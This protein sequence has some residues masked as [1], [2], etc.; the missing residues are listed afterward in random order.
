MKKKFLSAFGPG[1]ITGASDDDPSGI[2]TYSQVGAQF[3]LGMLWTMLFSFPLMGAI[4]EISAWIGRVTGHGIADNLRRHYPPWLLRSLVALLFVANTLNLAADL[5][6]MGS[7][8][9]LGIG[10]P[11]FLYTV[12]FALGSMTLEVFIPYTRYVKVLKWLTL[13]LFAYVV[14]AFMIH[15]PW[16]AALKATFVPHLSFQV[17][18]LTAFIAVLGTTISP[19]M[20]FWQASEE[21]E[22][23]QVRRHDHA[24]KDHP[25]EAPRQ[26]RRIRIDTYIGMAFSNI[27]AYFIILA[28]ATTL[29][30]HGVTDIQTAQQAAQALEPLAGHLAFLLFTFGIV[31]TG[32]LAVPV[33][34]GSAAYALGESLGWRV[35]LEKRPRQAKRFY[36][37][38]VVSTSLGLLLNILQLNPIRALFW[39]AVINGLVAVP[40]LAMMMVLA[41]QPKVMGA[42]VLPKYLRILG[43]LATAIMGAAAIGLLATSAHADDAPSEWWNLHAQAT[44][45]PQG[46]APFHADY[47][48]PNSLAATTDVQATLTSTLFLGVRL[49]KGGALYANPE[50]DGGAG[51]STGF[52]VAGFPNGEATRV[53]SGGLRL[54]LSRLFYRQT[55]DVGGPIEQQS[56]EAN[57]LAAPLAQDHWT[58]TFGKYAAT[59]IFDQN[60]YAHDPRTQFMNWALM[61]NAAWDFP[62][63]SRGYTWGAA[64]EWQQAEWSWR[65]GGFLLPTYA[66]GPDLDQNIAHAHGVVSE[67]ERRVHWLN[68]PGTWRLLGFLNEGF[69]GDYRA[70]LNTPEFGEDITRTRGAG[71][72]KYGYGLNID[73][74]FTRDLGGF[75]RAGWNDGHTETWAFTE[76]DRTLSLGLSLNGAAWRRAED[77][78]GFAGAINALSPDHRAYLAA[79]GLGFILGDGRLNYGTENILETYYALKLLKSVTFTVDAQGI[80]NPG[81]NRDRGPAAVFAGRLHWEL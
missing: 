74:E 27:V 37:I 3:G 73:Q 4:Q 44:Y 36:A 23:V 8:L 39:S 21:A 25:E 69:M 64:L 12:L 34:A 55:L 22:E 49:W 13:V 9:S 62:A 77:T 1:L 28:T 20:A 45:L 51:L 19:Y 17:G 66:N 68:H 53:G 47:S 10:G 6:A 31:G 38:I 75:L 42:F 26:F 57:Q 18:Y 54:Y 32:L 60:R 80:W 2:A 5:G 58:F 43:W 59:D 72:R 15:V 67:I 29:H 46:H 41:T 24:L 70:T 79:G 30:A 11:A 48:G 7:C 63:N 50:L 65:A 56:S 61:D 81:Y 78:V 16:R 33:L 40:S 35:G 71:A 14:T 76:V 52:G